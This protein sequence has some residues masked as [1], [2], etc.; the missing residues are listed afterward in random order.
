[1]N[2]L[3]KQFCRAIFENALK[4]EEKYETFFCRQFSTQDNATKIMN[5]EQR[6]Q[7]GDDLQQ[8]LAHHFLS[9]FTH[10]SIFHQLLT[11]SVL[12]GNL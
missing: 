9:L 1:M 7:T 4:L 12:L 2:N 5:K 11:S 3:I 6:G 10:P 8:E